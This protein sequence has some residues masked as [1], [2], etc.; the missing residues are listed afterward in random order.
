M[1]PTAAPSIKMR[2]KEEEGGYKAPLK[3]TNVAVCGGRKKQR[4][5]DEGRGA[6][7]N[8]FRRPLL[9]PIYKP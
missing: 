3:A 5:E 9:A 2:E 8:D 1:S 7:E 6:S 4:K